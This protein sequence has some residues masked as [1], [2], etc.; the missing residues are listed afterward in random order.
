MTHFT[1]CHNNCTYHVFGVIDH[2]DIG[3]QLN[4][5]QITWWL[6]ENTSTVKW[7]VKKRSW[8]SHCFFVTKSAPSKWYWVI[9]KIKIQTRMLLVL[10]S[11]L[12]CVDKHDLNWVG[13]GEYS[14]ILPTS[15]SQN[16][17]HKAYKPSID[18]DILCL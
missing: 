9:T 10:H 17:W 16:S 5:V 11:S 7:E 15:K 4:L 2:F 3:S 8:V 1:L 13:A 6:W 12:L 18:T 14:L